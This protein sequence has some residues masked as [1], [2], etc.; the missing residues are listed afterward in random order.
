MGARLGWGLPYFS[1]RMSLE[2]QGDETLFTS[3]RNSA[4]SHRVRYRIRKPLGP[5]EP[6]TL[7]HFLLERYLLFTERKGRVTSGQVY[8]TPYPARSAELIECDDTMAAAAGLQVGPTPQHVH[9]SD[10]VDVELFGL[11]TI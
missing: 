2:N 6:G 8:H 10:G 3:K 7:E 4:A 9:Y 5:S 1:A 11:Q